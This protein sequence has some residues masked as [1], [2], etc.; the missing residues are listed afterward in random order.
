MP[1]QF[2]ITIS[3]LATFHIDYLN[4]FQR[5][6]LPTCTVLSA[7]LISREPFDGIDYFLENPWLVL[8]AFLRTLAV[9]DY[10][11]RIVAVAWNRG[12]ARYRFLR[13]VGFL[14]ESA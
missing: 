2:Q 5:T 12:S 9:V 13:T 11:P 7:L 4:C 10:L 6:N 14:E 1:S 8:V 3:C